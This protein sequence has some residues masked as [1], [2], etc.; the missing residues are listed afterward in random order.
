MTNPYQINNEKLE[1]INALIHDLNSEQL[2]WLN[3]YISG[4]IGGKN[5]NVKSTAE[6][7]NVTSEKITILYGTHT[8]HSKEIALELYYRVSALGF[9][10]KL[11]ALDEY[12]KTDLKKEEHFFLIVSTHGEGEPPI[13]AEDFHEYVLGKRAPKLNDTNFRYWLWAINLIRSTVRQESILMKPLK[14]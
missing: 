10:P 12:K 1:Q 5:G 9:T 6:L 14:N 8:G 3:G 2:V 7:A 4:L 13:Q 11:K